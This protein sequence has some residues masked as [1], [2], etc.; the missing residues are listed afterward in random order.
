MAPSR[1][2]RSV[3]GADGDHR[4]GD[5]N[6]CH[7]RD[8]AAAGDRRSDAPR[9]VRGDPGGALVVRAAAAAQRHHRGGHH[10]GI[11]MRHGVPAVAVR[12]GHD[13]DRARDGGRRLV[14]GSGRRGP[15]DRGGH[16]A[17]SGTRHQSSPRPSTGAQFRQSEPASAG[18]HERLDGL[19]APGA[20]ARRRRCVGRATLRRVHRHA[21]D[22]DREHA[23]HGDRVGPVLRRSGGVRLTAGAGG[24]VGR[25]SADVDRAD[26]DPRGPV[27][28]QRAV[29][30]PERSAPGERPARRR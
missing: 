3:R 30:G 10:G 13:R 25:G 17:R 2:P 16:R 27:G 14:G 8:R 4:A 11:P 7:Q 28:A 21:R 20:G 29:T 1:A 9:G 23:P 26:P 15:G 5:T 18:G 19:P 24:G 6:C 12:R 22:P